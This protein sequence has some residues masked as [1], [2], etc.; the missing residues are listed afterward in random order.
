MKIITVIPLAKSAFREDLTYFSAQDITIGSIVGIPMRNKKILG[1]VVSSEDA[2]NIKSDIKSMTFNLKKIIDT[3]EKVLFRKEFLDS[4]FEVS[5]YFASKKSIG[6]ASLIPMAFQNEYEKLKRSPSLTLPKG[7]GKNAVKSEKLLLQSPTEDRII[8]YKTLI[9]SSFAEKKSV[10]VVLPTEYDIKNFS[11]ILSKGIENFSFAIHG[12]LSPKKQI[13]LFEKIASLEHPVLIFATAP[14]LCIPRADTGTII[15][16]HES[17]NAYR[18]ISRPNFDLRVFAELFASKINAQFIL[19]DTLLRFETIARRKNNNFGEARPL[20]FRINFDGHLEIITPNKDK[21]AT[22]KFQIFSDEVLKEMQKV[23]SKGKNVF[24]F[25]LRKGLAT[26]TICRDCNQTITC[27]TCSAPVVLYLSKDGNKRMFACNRCNS[28]KN[29]EMTCPRCGSWNLMPLGIGTDTVTE[30][31]KQ[32]LPDIKIFKLDKESAKTA[33]EAEKIMK[34]YEEQS[35]SILV[36]TEMAFFYL[37]EKV[38][39]SVIASFDSL[40]S[41]PNFKMSEKII[42]LVFSI[43]SKTKEKLIIQTKNENDPA[44]L[45]IKNFFFCPRGIRRKKEPRLS[46]I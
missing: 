43:I 1:L 26:E 25:S 10:F 12:G 4:A 34:E 29:P 37:K 45:A 28:E 5:E 6:I 21:G 36:G 15:L 9:R 35:G 32:S 33:K 7:D 44:I 23:L 19:S 13:S 42:Q 24:V 40:W 2:Q 17:S 39:F 3:G 14:Y 46:A 31:L 18:M 11:E 16:E 38:Y 8:Y 22:A 27:E 41:V 30:E 20:S